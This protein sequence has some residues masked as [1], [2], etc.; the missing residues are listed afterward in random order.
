MTSK[1]KC[2]HPDTC[3]TRHVYNKLYECLTENPYLC[4][5]AFMFGNRYFC[6]NPVNKIVPEDNLTTSDDNQT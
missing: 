2:P 1:V 3:L 6:N 5:H 4:L